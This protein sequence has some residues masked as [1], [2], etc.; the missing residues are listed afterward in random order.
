MQLTL[1]LRSIGKSKG[2]KI[3][4]N[5]ELFQSCMRISNSVPGSYR[6]CFMPQGVAFGKISVLVVLLLWGIKKR[7][8]PRECCFLEN[9][10]SCEPCVQME[11]RGNLKGLVKNLSTRAAQSVRKPRAK[12]GMDVPI[13]QGKGSLWVVWSLGSHLFLHFY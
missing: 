10:Y 3:V 13:S 11:V 5:H 4:T 6:V 12:A 8:T 9:C 1:A 7:K 2:I